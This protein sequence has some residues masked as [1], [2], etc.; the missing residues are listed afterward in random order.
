MTKPDQTRLPALDS[1]R[2]L[3]AL[4]VVFAH[5]LW[6]YRPNSLVRPFSAN[7]LTVG[8]LRS[9]VAERPERF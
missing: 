1:L 3:A 2:G 5:V 7:L 6:L 8:Y 4:T 9:W